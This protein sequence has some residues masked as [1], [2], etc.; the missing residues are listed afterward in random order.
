LQIFPV[1]N[2]VTEVI[3]AAHGH[4]QL[5][6]VDNYNLLYIIP[7][8]TATEFQEEYWRK[9]NSSINEDLNLRGYVKSY[10][11]NA[12]Q[13][14]EATIALAYALQNTSNG[15]VYMTAWHAFNHFH[16]LLSHR[17]QRKPDTE[18]GSCP[19]G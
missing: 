2:L 4:S 19:K 17:F 13:C 10:F 6:F 3:S 15:K 14:H 11:N 16:L 12:E 1:Y 5:D 8:Q 7:Q 9:I 18:H